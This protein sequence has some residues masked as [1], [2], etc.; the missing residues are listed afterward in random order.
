MI[1]PDYT[2]YSNDEL[3]DAFINI[4]DEQYPD[5]AEQLYQFIKGRYT[6]ESNQLAL[7]YENCN[8]GSLVS[9]F[10]ILA[11]GVDTTFARKCLDEKIKRVIKRQKKIR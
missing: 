4:D 1:D 7:E 2:K 3:L 11:L 5:R 8:S 6:K 10:S 9:T